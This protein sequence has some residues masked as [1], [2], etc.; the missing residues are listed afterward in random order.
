MGRYFGHLKNAFLGQPKGLST[1]SYTEMWSRFS[2]YGMRAIILFYMY[3][4]LAK[5]GL[6]FSQGTAASIMSIY[7]SLV[8]LSYIIGGY[9]S[10]RMLGS[11]KSVFYGAILILFGN[12]LLSFPLGVKTLFLS[13]VLIIMGT[14]LFGPN[15]TN[16]VGNLYDSSGFQREIGF[17]IFVFSTNV[18]AFFAPI[19]VGGLG[20][21][22]NFHFGFLLSAIA[23]LI[24]LIQYY[25]SNKNNFNGDN[26]YP[27][28]PIEPQDVKK[29][30][31]KTILFLIG[32]VL[33]ISLMIVM[34]ELNIKNL[35]TL[36]SIFVIAVPII[37]FIV[38]LLSNKISKQ[39]HRNL[40]KYIPFFIVAVIFWGIEEQGS[41]ILALFA[42]NQTDNHIL[43][44]TLPASVYQSLNP[45]FFIL[46]T[47]FFIMVWNKMNQNKRKANAAHMFSYGMI[48]TGLSF[49]WMVIPLLLFGL[50]SKISPFWLIGSWAIIEIGEMLI[51]PIG[52]S[53]TTELSPKAYKSQMLALWFLADAAGQAINSQIIKLYSVNEVAYFAWIGIIV[54]AVGILL[55]IVVK[56]NN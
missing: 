50:S 20:M 17:T 40:L 54:I 19:I 30:I 36:S 23:M 1:L 8:Y 55:P 53:I 49:L 14:G 18:G 12:L 2:Y 9:V 3:Y 45:L 27:T 7:G 11:Q 39:E 35:I 41:V 44:F 13:M 42:Q 4:S 24:G 47:P 33:I 25:F 22:I 6:G 34:N 32:F 26:L 51:S 21:R 52:L 38:M 16:I 37:Y 31:F 43:G 48:F 10:D 28:N 5:G 15:I 29:I 46:Y 56:K